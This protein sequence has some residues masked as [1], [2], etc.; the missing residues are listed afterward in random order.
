MP[1]IGSGSLMFTPYQIVG[2]F[3]TVPS[4]MKVETPHPGQEKMDAM[5]TA[6][7]GCRR[8]LVDW[9]RSG[10]V[11]RLLGDRL[12]SRRVPAGQI[13]RGLIVRHPH[14]NVRTHH[15]RTGIRGHAIAHPG[16]GDMRAQRYG[17]RIDRANTGAGGKTGRGRAVQIVTC[18]PDSQPM[19]R[20]GGSGRVRRRVRGFR[21]V[22]RRVYTRLSSLSRVVDHGTRLGRYRV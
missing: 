7:W 14:V 19:G 9:A 8:R 11:F 12:P 22:D 6:S 21:R 3:S 5:K 16:N 17:I 15:C 13:E 2:G 1:S 4:Y 20:A 18:D 10:Q